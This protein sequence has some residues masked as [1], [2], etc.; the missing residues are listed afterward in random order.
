VRGRPGTLDRR[1]F[2]SI[3]GAAF[4]AAPFHALACRAARRDVPP[5]LVDA[6]SSP[7]RLG[8]G[9]LAPVRDDTTRL[10]L[11]DL[12]SGFR[13]RSFGWIGDPLAR[14][15]AT[16][17]LHDGMAAFPA[18]GG[19]V[20]LVRN[21]ELR[22]GPAIAPRPIYDRNGCGGTT[23][24]EYDARTGSVTDARVSLAGTAVNC[25]G[26]P[27]PWDSWL[28]CEETVLG[29][30]GGNDFEEPHGY[31]FEVP[32]DGRA[33]AAPLRAMGRF[34]HEAIAVDPDTGIVY[35]TEDQGTSGFYRFLPDEAGVLSA[36][37]R[38]EM[39]CIADA[40]RADLRTG[41]AAGLWRPV[42]WAP[43]DDPDPAEVDQGSVFEQGVAGGGAAFARLEGTWYGD[44]RIYI[45]STTGGE[46]AAGQVWEYDPRGERVRLIFESPGKD[47]LDMPDNLCVSPRGGLV[48]CE[49]G[50]T[51]NFVRGL[52][53]DGGIFP[54]ARNNVVLDGERNGFAGDF[55]AREFAGA[56]YSPDGRWLFFNAQTPGITFAV[57]GPWA[58]GSL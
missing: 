40:P 20:R 18:R 54:F 3:A 23:T 21:H 26:G 58:G 7:S 27:T 6:S 37:G 31:I 25:A 56:A 10:P 2:L 52:A 24:V 22:A 33:T 32:A 17:G 38:L 30:G 46:A 19:R 9:P 1:A 45:V 42:S 14:G 49:D 55:R 29:P 4:G 53:L 44:G 43:I 11:L 51:D 12:P 57:T 50:A 41:Q 15:L 16:P 8:Y 34:V 35:E 28:T 47:V 5:S 36:G 13:Y 39:L 48:L